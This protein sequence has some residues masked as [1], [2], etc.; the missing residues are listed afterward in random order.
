MRHPALTRSLRGSVFMCVCVSFGCFFIALLVIQLRV[1]RFR[2]ILHKHPAKL[3]E[4]G[5][6]VGS[7]NEDL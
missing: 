3:P 4:S 1:T 6:V 5:T 2:A 7:A